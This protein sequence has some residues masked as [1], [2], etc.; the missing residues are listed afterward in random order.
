MTICTYKLK[1][2]CKL[3]VMERRNNTRTLP[4]R[5]GE[6]VVVHVNGPWFLASCDHVVFGVADATPS[7]V[8]LVCEMKA[9]LHRALATHLH[10]V[11]S[12]QV[13]VFV[14]GYGVIMND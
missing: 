11:N 14:M 2:A 1:K 12:C 10:W 7:I 4:K 8:D 5:N 3:T 6:D 13:Q 9:A